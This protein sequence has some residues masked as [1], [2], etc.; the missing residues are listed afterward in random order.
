MNFVRI[1]VSLT[2]NLHVVKKRNKPILLDVNEF[3]WENI[4]KLVI[5][6]GVTAEFII[7]GIN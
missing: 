2:R 5:R 4:G 1:Q 6:V 3:L 7:D